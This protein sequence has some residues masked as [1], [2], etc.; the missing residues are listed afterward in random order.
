MDE[1]IKEEQ[2]YKIIITNNE[3]ENEKKEENNIII[4]NKENDIEIER[5]KN[6]KRE[7]YLS[8]NRRN[9]YNYSKS[10]SHVKNNMK[11]RMYNMIKVEKP[12][13]TSKYNLLNKHSL[14]ELNECIY[15]D[16]SQISN[17]LPYYQNYYFKNK[18]ND[19]TNYKNTSNDSIL[20]CLKYIEYSNFFF[21]S[22]ISYKIQ[23]LLFNIIN[24]DRGILDQEKYVF[25]KNKLKEVYNKL[26]PYQTRYNYLK[27]FYGRNPEESLYYL[28]KRDLD[29]IN[30][31]KP[32][33][34]KNLNYLY[35]IFEIVR[36]KMGTKQ[37]YIKTYFN[38]LYNN[39]NGGNYNNNYMNANMNHINLSQI[40][41]NGIN[42][43]RQ[44]FNQYPANNISNFNNMETNQFKINNNKEHNFKGS[45]PT[46]HNNNYF[47]KNRNNSYIKQ[48][49]VEL[50]EPKIKETEHIINNNIINNNNEY[51]N[52]MNHNIINMNDNNGSP[53]W[54]NNI[55]MNINNKININNLKGFNPNYINHN[56]YD[57]L[58]N[59]NNNMQIN[60]NGNIIQNNLNMQNMNNNSNKNIQK[61]MK[62]NLPPKINI[63]KE[64]EKESTNNINININYEMNKE[65]DNKNNE[66]NDMDF[67]Y[68][69]EEDKNKG[70]KSNSDNCLPK[71]IYNE[72]ENEEKTNERNT[73]NFLMNDI[74]YNII[75]K[76]LITTQNY[77]TTNINKY[78]SQFAQFNQ[79]TN[80]YIAYISTI[81]NQGILNNIIFLNQNTYNNSKNNHYNNNHNNKID[82]L[83][84]EKIIETEYEKLGKLK[85]ENP[86]KISENLKLFE[87]YILL[88]IYNE[89]NSNSNTPEISKLYSGVYLKYNK[90]SNKRK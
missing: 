90:F 7:K 82:I 68:N 65:D 62:I 28:F 8:I 71:I 72:N 56:I 49:L 14:K 74:D 3:N 61:Q 47:Y 17:I 18:I 13:L 60:L 83:K 12:F 70:K 69:N 46:R 29:K 38:R 9:P 2:N 16:Y 30:L 81:Y 80:L 6:K 51:I 35:E 79:N 57:N 5:D 77:L 41:Y 44:S 67:L 89:I 40:N 50:D 26:I 32:I 4:N 39:K 19:Y 48:E 42:D 58:N 24:G 45:Y 59:N 63:K 43:R 27:T 54:N 88:P 37:D 33:G 15:K 52:L 36:Q 84:Q 10:P 87:N 20:I 86:S 75:L 78:I 22:D 64:G 31:S 76:Q 53:F 73:K 25:L 55:N 23:N 1:P 11:N 34:I 21:N 85:M 66:I